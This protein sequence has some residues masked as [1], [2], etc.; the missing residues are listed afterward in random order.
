V[1]DEEREGTIKAYGV[2]IVKGVDKSTSIH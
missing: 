2:R 1:G